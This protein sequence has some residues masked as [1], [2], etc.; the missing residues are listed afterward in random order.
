MGKCL[1]N[2]IGQFRLTDAAYLGALCSSLQHRQV[3]S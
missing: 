2:D 3:E 1:G